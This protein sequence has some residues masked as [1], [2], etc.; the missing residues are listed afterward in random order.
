MR[1]AGRLKKRAPLFLIAGILILCVGFLVVSCGTKPQKKVETITGGA[2]AVNFS[3]CPAVAN[4][5][6]R[7][8]VDSE[9]FKKETNKLMTGRELTAEAW[10]KIHSASTS[11]AI[12]GRMDSAG[13]YLYVESGVPKVVVRRAPFPTGTP[14]DLIVNGAP[15]LTV[16]RWTHLA[17]VLR[18]PAA[19]TS[20]LDLYIDGQSVASAGAAVDP[21]DR[22]EPGGN[23][24]SA[25]WFGEGPD[26]SG[27]PNSSKLDAAVDEARLWGV[28]RTQSE[29]QKC[30]GME[31]GLDGSVCGRETDD[32]IG[33]FRFNEGSGHS[34]SEWSGL[35]PG[36]KEYTDL[37]SSNVPPIESWDTGWVDGAP[38]SPKD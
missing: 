25:G 28:A 19:A 31:L 38:I 23:I 8:L 27:V 2:Y 15:A 6:C 9:V 21:T 24:M 12:F 33:Y 30:M 36:A 18:Y 16:N 13:I 14:I 32:L 10:V 3:A 4:G 22:T 29:I 7:A 34:L 5:P 37:N 26:V 35:G 1:N 17:G 20:T 11:G